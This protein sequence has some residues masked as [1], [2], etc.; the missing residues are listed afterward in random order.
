MSSVL[1]DFS[2]ATTA[3]VRETARR[4]VSLNGRERGSLSGIVIAPGIIVTAEEALE[5]DGDVEVTLPDGQAATASVV[6]RDPT[7]DIAVLRVSGADIA[8]APGAARPEA[9]AIVVGVGRVGKDVVAALGSLAH[10]GDAWHS[11]HGGL[12]ELMIRAD[13]TLRPA[14]EGGALVDAGGNLVGMAVFGP[15][16]RVIA[17]P[18]A[19]LTRVSEHILAH[20]SVARGYVGVSV[21]AVAGAD[22]AGPGAIVV[23]LDQDGPAKSAGILLGDIVR[24][25]NGEPVTGTRSIIDRLG[26]SSVGQV[27]RLALSRAGNPVEVSVTVAARRT[28]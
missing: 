13:I 18:Q 7:T 2:D 22:Q 3:L 12:I 5:R 28:A 23:G 25:W 14:T 27:A 6:G 21:Q 16:R 19:T 1:K 20:G 8:A 10:V 9:G 26:P 15:R 11:S 17:I 4:V 24:T